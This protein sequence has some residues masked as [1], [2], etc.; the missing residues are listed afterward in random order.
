MHKWLNSIDNARRGI[1]L[2]LKEERNIKIELVISLM[3]II[4]SWWL[5]IS[6]IEWCI[7][8]LCIAGVI[9]AEAFNSALEK[10]SDEYTRDWNLKIRDVKDLAAGGVLIMGIASILI[11][12]LILGPKL[13]A[14]IL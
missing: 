2:L 5:S 8:V 11:G 12:L 7:I 4:L 14:R 1:V 13:I 10:L 6:V 9:G 3:A